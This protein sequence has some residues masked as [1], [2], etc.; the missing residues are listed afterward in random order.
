MRAIELER[1]QNPQIS[2]YRVIVRWECLWSQQKQIDCQVRRFA[3][4][5]NSLPQTFTWENFLK[6]V[7]DKKNY[8]TAGVDFQVPDSL[9][10]FLEE[11]RPTFK[12]TTVEKNNLS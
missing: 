7:S 9:K 1:E 5:S 3:Q 8:E 6:A 2:G 12:N 4:I 10:D 11:I